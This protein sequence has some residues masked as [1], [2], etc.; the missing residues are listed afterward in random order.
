V[1]IKQ[2]VNAGGWGRLSAIRI[3]EPKGHWGMLSEERVVAL[4]WGTHRMGY[5]AAIRKM[6][7]CVR[8]LSSPDAPAE[9]EEPARPSMAGSSP[10]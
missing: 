8:Q 6:A 7:E 10:E 5:A 1:E 4:V 9:T 2:D 3:E